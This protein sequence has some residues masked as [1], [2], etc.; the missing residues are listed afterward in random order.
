MVLL[1]THPRVGQSNR[2]GSLAST[3][4][5]NSTWKQSVSQSVDVVDRLTIE[6]SLNV[7]GRLNTQVGAVHVSAD[8]CYL[9][10]CTKM[11]T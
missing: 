4:A 8:M 5:C 9:K 7:Q 10:L 6:Q 11:Y 1:S 3:Q 2:A